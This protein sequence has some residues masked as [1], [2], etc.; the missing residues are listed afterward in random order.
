M[1]EPPKLEVG[2]LDGRASPGQLEVGSLSAT[3]WRDALIAGWQQS[4]T[5]L[6][7]EGKLPTRQM[8]SESPGFS[9]PLDF[10]GFTSKRAVSQLVGI[11]ADLPLSALGAVGGMALGSAVAPGAGTTIGAGA[12]ALALPSALR[13]ALMQAYQQGGV[14]TFDEA[15]DIIGAF[16]TEGGRGAALG[17][18]TA[19]AGRFVGQ[20]VRGS[21]TAAVR[22]TAPV[23]SQIAVLGTLGP[24]LHGQVPGLQDFLDAAIIVGGLHAATATAGRLMTIYAKTGKHPAEV[25]AE[26]AQNPALKAEIAKM[27]AEDIG[28]TKAV[29]TAYEAL[30][31]A[32]NAKAAV[33]MPPTPE[34]LSKISEFAARPFAEQSTIPGT[35][36]TVNFRYINTDAEINL[37][38]SRLT[39][40]LKPE[41]ET[42]RRGTVSHAETLRAAQEKLAEVLN[43]P[44]DRVPLA[45]EAGAP[46]NAA[47]LEAR[48]ILAIEAVRELKERRDEAVAAARD[49]TLTERDAADFYLHFQRTGAILSQFV[50]ASAEA[51]R[52][53]NIL[54]RVSEAKEEFE[55]VKKIVEESK[56]K[57][58]IEQA[59][60]MAKALEGAEDAAGLSAAVQ[61]AAKVGWFRKLTEIWKAGLVSGLSTHEVNLISGVSTNLVTQLVER[62][63]AATIGNVRHAVTGTRDFVSFAENMAFYTGA[64]KG[65]KDALRIAGR[66]LADENVSPSSL[67]D[68]VPSKVDQPP[69]GA[70]GGLPGRAT[71]VPFRTLSA[72]DAIFRVTTE[73]GELAGQAVRIAIG[74]GLDPRSAAYKTRLVE[75]MKDPTESQIKAAIEAGHAAVHTTPLGRIGATFEAFIQKAPILEWVLPF[76]RTPINLTKWAGRRLPGVGLLTPSMLAEL[77]AGG[78][79]RDLAIARQLTG[80]G[81][82]LLVWELFNS[83]AITGGFQS[84][85]PQERQAKFNNGE[86]PYSV[87]FAKLGLGSLGT[88][89]YARLDPIAP[90]VSLVTDILELT[91]NV[92]AVEERDSLVVTIAAVFG[93]AT[94]S[95]TYMKGLSDAF[96]GLTQSNIYGPRWWQS[97]VSSNV[98]AF[99][100]Q[101]ARAADPHEREVNSVLDAIRNRLPGLREQ[102]APRINPVTGGPVANRAESETGIPHPFMVS[103]PGT[104]AVAAEAARLGFSPGKQAKTLLVGGRSVGG[105]L[106]LKEDEIH[107]ITEL[108]GKFGH[109][110]MM[111]LVSSP[112]WKLLPDPLKLAQFRAA[113]GTARRLAILQSIDPDKRADVLNAALMALSP[114]E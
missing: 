95:K 2:P 52:A 92:E 90:I 59:E 24:A 99:L 97:L 72:E 21:T 35:P 63:V 67:T 30:A 109:D 18:V 39:E 5:G 70:I 101:I 66:I 11:G 10:L 3:S 34:M 17:A 96:K 14:N 51:G 31:A 71:R 103:T 108:T 107:R 16:L 78:A 105:K 102:L 33:P 32:E 6:L 82:G 61:K 73:Q 111:L 46:I 110:H 74:E 64:M 89:S 57:S 88:V 79:R 85:T 87:N 104:D 9:R 23:A 91:Q 54:R 50:G 93:N 26:A 56:G 47:E 98:P 58:L 44:A 69:V 37:A 22:A 114:S 81:I 65:A 83:G 1:A 49:G 13:G 19:G 77:K 94:L 42:Q 75:L 38:T 106:R 27:A 41:I 100:S 36:G 29:P 112:G 4:A 28:G 80:L 45:R 8:P 62:N 113:F 86:Q 84:L 15:L 40:L 7:F 20:A 68:R 76:R 55:A 53:L 25:A 12:G 43:V 48:R 60:A